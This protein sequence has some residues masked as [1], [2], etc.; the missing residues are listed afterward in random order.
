MFP[1]ILQTQTELTLDEWDKA[2]LPNEDGTSNRMDAPLHNGRSAA[3]SAASD[4]QLPLG[5]RQ[6][7]CG[8]D[9]AMMT[10]LAVPVSVRLRMVLNG[11]AWSCGLC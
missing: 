9:S 3:Q 11:T 7:W 4:P 5:E 1:N 2:L 6:R 8:V 10:W